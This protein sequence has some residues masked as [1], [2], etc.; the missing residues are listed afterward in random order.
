MELAKIDYTNNNLRAKKVY[1]KV[2]NKTKW[3]VYE[4]T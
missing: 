1:N 2:S 4:L 3:D